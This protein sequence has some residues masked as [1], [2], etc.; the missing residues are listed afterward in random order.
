MHYEL[1]PPERIQAQIEDSKRDPVLSRKPDLLGLF[2]RWSTNHS[3]GAERSDKCDA[4]V[5]II[6]S[7]STAGDLGEINTPPETVLVCFQCPGCGEGTTVEESELV[8]RD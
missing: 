4:L 1:P 5:A 8:F 2:V 7:V 3:H 6:T